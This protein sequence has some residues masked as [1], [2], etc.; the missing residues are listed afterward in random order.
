LKY[1]SRIADFNV[2]SAGV[3]SI[4]TVLGWL[5]LTSIRGFSEKI[6]HLKLGVILGVVIT[7][8]LLITDTTNLNVD[9]HSVIDSFWSAAFQGDY[10]YLAKSHMNNYPGPMPFYFL[11]LLPFWA[12][13]DVGLINL[14]LI[15]F[16]FLVH[17]D[18]TKKY[19]SLIGFLFLL[20][21]FWWEVLTR[22]NVLVN[23]VFM[24]AALKFLKER[25]WI[26]AAITIGLVMSMRSIFILP[27]ITTFVLLM[28]IG[29][30]SLKTILKTGILA[31][32]VFICTFLPFVLGNWDS[33]LAMNP[34]LVQ[35]SFLIPPVYIPLFIVIAVLL[36]FFTKPGKF[37]FAN[38]LSLFA[39]IL[40][41]LIYHTLQGTWSSA[42]MNSK[43]DISYFIFCI[44]FF[45]EYIH[46]SGKG[47]VK[48]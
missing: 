30:I 38:A 9:R 37:Y 22:S 47:N 46:T 27:L 35:S 10:P 48:N 11:I 41:Y 44:P 17:R 36:G 42:L 34:F 26:V 7:S 15:P 25:S 5:F 31:I 21:P 1:G 2:L 12:L 19:V 29:T 13:G 33:F 32:G 45:L 24:L 39:P 6:F 3:L 14:A 4:L 40:I 8:I 43:A 23:G 18:E 16:L 20:M 28:R